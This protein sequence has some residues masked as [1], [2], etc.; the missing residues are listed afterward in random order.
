MY[1]KI[2]WI[3][4]ASLWNSTTITMLIRGFGFSSHLTQPSSSSQ[5]SASCVVTSSVLSTSSV[6]NMSSRNTNPAAT[7][8]P[9]LGSS[10][11]TQPS[12]NHLQDTRLYHTL[13]RPM[14]TFNRCQVE[15]PD[16]SLTTTMSKSKS[17][18]LVRSSRPIYSWSTKSWRLAFLLSKDK[19][20]LIW[21]NI[22]TRIKVN[23]FQ[24]I[25]KNCLIF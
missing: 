12:G 25:F 5:S 22:S 7:T 3:L 15:M 1:E 2:Y 9:S 19:Q 14:T 24:F 13:G 10:W 11:R 20:L 16:E 21:N 8:I 4:P 17:S 6:S 23:S 18:T